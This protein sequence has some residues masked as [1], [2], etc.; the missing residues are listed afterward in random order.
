MT[1]FFTIKSKSKLLKCLGFLSLMFLFSLSASA[2]TTV[3]GVVSDA[4]GPIPGANVNIKGTKTGVVT[5]FD[6]NYTITN[7]PSNGVLVFSFLGLTT[8][9]VPVAGKTKIDAVLQENSNALQEVVVIGYG[10]QRKEAVTGSVASI[11]G[12]IVREVPSANITQALQGR[13]AGVQM[14]QTSSKPGAEMQIRIRGTRS[15]TA[16]NNPL[17]VLDGIPFAG[18]IGDIS[19]DNIKSIDIL[20]D[21]SATAIY[22]SRGANG[23]ILIST[24]KGQ[25]GQKATFTYNTY[26]GL[27]NIFAKFPMMN[28]SEFVALRK[29][30]TLPG[31]TAPLYTNG[32]DEADNVNTDWQDLMFRSGI[33]TNHDIGVASGTE[34]GNYNFGASYYKE[35][36]VLPGQDYARLTLRGAVDQAVG[37][38]FK[39]GFTTNNNYSIS[40]GGNLGLYSTLSTTPIANPYNACLLYTSPSPRDS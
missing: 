1:N 16:D 27:K 12:D 18:S 37:K 21:A 4:Q 33:V 24:N 13:L 22:G 25:K 31:S 29:I 36:A 14:T 17:V 3:S 38:Y 11:K 19:P 26:S 9:E 28:N 2:Q 34:T 32:P 15:L 8:K 40:N 30:A 5:G 6:G 39:F 23:V 20:K 10:T 7:V 35:E